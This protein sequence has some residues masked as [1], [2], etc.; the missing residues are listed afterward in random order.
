MAIALGRDVGMR[1]LEAM[2]LHPN[3]I[4]GFELRFWVDEAVTM[5]VEQYVTKDQAEGVE[6]ILKEYELIEREPKPE[7]I[8]KG[9]E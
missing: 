9:L 8:S 1:I 6:T 5:K 7:K 2:G 4:R 3:E